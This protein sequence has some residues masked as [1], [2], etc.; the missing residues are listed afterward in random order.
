M[1]IF[2]SSNVFW[3]HFLDAKDSHRIILLDRV[4]LF[5]LIV[6]CCSRGSSAL[7]SLLFAINGNVEQC[8]NRRR[9]PRWLTVATLL[10]IAR[11]VDTS[12]AYLVILTL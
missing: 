1:M 5:Y 10:T 8:G 3:F 2:I 12:V 6:W 4:V 7:G 11:L 9:L